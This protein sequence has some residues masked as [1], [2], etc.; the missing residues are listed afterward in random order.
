MGVGKFS[1]DAKV[2]GNSDI[3]QGVGSM[4]LNLIGTSDDY[5]IYV[6]KG[7][8]SVNI[9]GKN[10]KDDENFGNGINKIDID[11][12]VGSINIDFKNIRS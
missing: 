9:D 2:L 10:V 4:D 12:G 5:Q 1:L 8:G 3:E 6:D 11:G 7:L